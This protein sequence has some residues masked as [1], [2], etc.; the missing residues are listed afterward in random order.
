MEKKSRNNKDTFEV[1]ITAELTGFEEEMSKE[2]VPKKK[3]VSD[4]QLQ[5]QT[6]K[7][8]YR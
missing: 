5:R 3:T 4:L 6:R 8:M 1:E 7:R 2:E